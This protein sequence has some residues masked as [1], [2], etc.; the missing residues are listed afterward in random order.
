VHS[1]KIIKCEDVDWIQLVEPN[2]VGT[3]TGFLV[4]CDNSI[5]GF[6]KAAHFLTR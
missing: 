5:L 3:T 2:S 6:I 1:T 4:H